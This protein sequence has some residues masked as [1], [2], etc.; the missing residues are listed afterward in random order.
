MGMPDCT[1]IMHAVQ[2]VL[3]K[4][5]VTVRDRDTVWTKTIKTD[6]CKLGRDSFGCDVG[7]S[8]VAESN[9]N[10]GE[11]LYDVTWL[12]YD[13]GS[14]RRVVAAPLVAECE[15]GTFDDIKDDFDK[16]LLAHATVRLMIYDGGY[17]PGTKEIAQELATRVKKFSGSPAQDG[18]L[19]A[20]WERAK[21]RDEWGFNYFRIS[22]IGVTPFPA[23]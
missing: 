21:C 9:R 20:A 3:D 12:K 18:W 17:K 13:E 7:A 22:P 14:P 15:W 23:R 10:F 6:L 8:N 11:W 16:L 5:N 19:L 4:I 2:E 1:E